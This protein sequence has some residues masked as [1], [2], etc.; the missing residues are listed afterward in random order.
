MWKWEEQTARRSIL[1]FK[2]SHL[3]QMWTNSCYKREG[4]WGWNVSQ[5]VRLIT[6]LRVI[7]MTGKQPSW[8]TVFLRR[9]CQLAS[10]FHI[11]NFAAIYFFRVKSSA[12]RLTPWRARSL[13]LCPPLTGRPIYVLRHR[14][15]FSSPPTTRR[16]R[17]DF[18]YPA[19]TRG[20]STITEQ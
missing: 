2:E 19:S 10:G 12:L 7:T 17:V 15:P 3:R 5:E 8:A 18:F 14:V 4:I 1:G 9:F 20:S 13:Y 11:F 16:T 6:V